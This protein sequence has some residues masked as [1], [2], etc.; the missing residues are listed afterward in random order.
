MPYQ[1]HK[2]MNKTILITGAN[3][4]LGKDAA[5]QLALLPATE[6]IYLACR[7]LEKAEIA[8]QEL[9]KQTN[10]D[11]FEIL[12]MDVSDPVSVR[13]AV[14]QLDA[15]VDAL[16]MNAGGMGGK[17]P[18]KT[19]KDGVT[20][21]FAHNLLG[22]VVLVDELTRANKLNNVAL[23]AGS[24]AARGVKKMGMKRPDLT[25][26][27]LE[28]FTSII[29]GSYFNGKM[30]PMAAYGLV[31]YIA[32]LWIAAQA[33][34]HPNIRFIT[35]SPGSTKGTSVMDDLSGIQ[36]I[37]FKYIMMPVVM[38]LTGLVH[39]LE[40]GARR[41]VDGINDESLQSGVF[42]GSHANVLTGPLIDQSTLFPDLNNTT[43][44]DNADAAIHRFI[45]QDAKSAVRVTS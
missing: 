8:R 7:S 15:P 45:P 28:E 22:H 19:T 23:Y 11:I 26:S 41:Y 6:K 44:Q 24:E 32:A 35:M 4:G 31:K 29:D 30:D 40:K 9:K 2:N 36:K 3:S 12:P 16:I 20:S 5:R 43:F 14:S 27:S 37:M 21:I 17:A 33:R 38:P 1:K 10:R 34:K 25:S 42:Y 18:G 39:S 13:S